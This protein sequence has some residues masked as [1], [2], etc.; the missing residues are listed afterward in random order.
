MTDLTLRTDAG[1]VLRVVLDEATTEALRQQL[2]AGGAVL[3]VPAERVEFVQ[4]RPVNVGDFAEG[5]KR[6]L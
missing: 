2:D 5:M 3:D 4:G 1:E 6:Y